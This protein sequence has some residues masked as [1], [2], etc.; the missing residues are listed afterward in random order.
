[1]NTRILKVLCKYNLTRLPGRNFV[2]VLRNRRGAVIGWAIAALVTVLPFQR[3]EFSRAVR[4]IVSAGAAKLAQV[5]FATPPTDISAN[6]TGS[7]LPGA[8]IPP[9]AATVI[10]A[11]VYTIDIS[12]NA[13]V[14]KKGIQIFTLDPGGAIQRVVGRAEGSVKDAN[15]GEHPKVFWLQGYL[16]GE[17]LAYAYFAE[18]PA[19]RTVGTYTWTRVGD[20]YEGN[21]VGVDQITSKQIHSA[22]VMTTQNLSIEEARSRFPILQQSPE[23]ALSRPPGS[24][25]FQK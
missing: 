24:I 3:P 19:M 1:M 22:A 2:N 6:P 23:Y 15:G 13:Y 9:G 17:N 18:N 20:H 12:G 5:R 21:W 11:W 8:Q 10:D 7:G 14:L 16:S 25:A 4:E